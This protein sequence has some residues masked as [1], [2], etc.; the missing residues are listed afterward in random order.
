MIL[1]VSDF[2]AALRFIAGR[3]K[4]LAAYLFSRSNTARQQLID[5]S[6]SGSIAFNDV[7]VQAGVQGCPSAAWAPAALAAAMERWGS[8]ASQTKNLSTNGPL[9]SIWPGAIPLRKQAVILK[10]LLG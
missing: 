1:E 4:P 9:H 2:E 5:R 3:P 7:I 10:R 8:A 6:Q